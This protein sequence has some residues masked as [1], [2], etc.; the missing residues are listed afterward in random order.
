MMKSYRAR[1]I[2]VLVCL[3]VLRALYVAYG[4]F[5][6]SPDEAHYWDWSRRLDLSYYS[7]GPMVAYVIAFFTSIFGATD[8]GVRIGTV[9]LS[10]LSSYMIFMLGRELFESEK[11][12]FYAAL[13]VNAVPLYSIGAIL[14]TTD[15]LLVFFWAASIYSLKKAIDGDKYW[16][17][18]SGA[19]IGLGFLGKY[20]AVLL[21]P[22]VALYL[23][24]VREQRHWLKRFEPYGAGLLS[25]VFATPVIYW[26]ISHGQ[27]TIKHTMGQ[28]GTEAAFLP[29]KSFFDFLGS[30]AGLVTPLIFAGLVYGAII[31]GREGF[32]SKK[33][34]LLLAF[35]ASAPVFLLFLFKSLHGK[36]QGNWAVASYVTAVPAAVWAITLAYDKAARGRKKIW[37]GVISV[38]VV[39]GAV[40]SILAY[41]PWPLEALGAKKMISGPPYNRVTGWS[42]LGDKVSGIKRMMD[43]AGSGVPVFIMSDTY[44]IASE[45][46]FYVDGNPVVYNVDTGSRRMNQ[47]D[48]WPGFEGFTGQDAL[49]VKGGAESIEPQVGSAFERCEKE[50]VR[51]T[52]REGINKDF[53]V[54]RCYGFKGMDRPDSHERY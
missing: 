46:A 9:I 24:T 2:A 38:G 1:L 14:M 23:F 25:L 44:Q 3:A 48:L 32:R 21:Y 42:G 29:W 28:A 22:V 52:I 8:F 45:L 13:L 27:V 15:A 43:S 39:L 20:I 6:L 49:Y 5:D 19:L 18:V 7:K 47:Y 12:G 30:Q 36:V 51:I 35:F 50:A 40:V 37:K 10:A 31:C 54:F 33:N 4:P 53:S 26:N 41:F 11:V 16:W 34:G 17:Y